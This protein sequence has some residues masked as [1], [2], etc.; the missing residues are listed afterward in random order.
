MRTTTHESQ[1]AWRLV[2]LLTGL[3]ALAAC[4]RMSPEQYAVREII[5]VEIQS[6]K[7]LTV[8]IP[9]LSGN[10]WN[11][12][13][14]RC[15]PEVWKAVTN[16]ARP[17]SGRLK[18]STKP[19]TEIG[20]VGLGFGFAHFLGSLSDVHY[21]FHITGKDGAKASVEITFPNAPSGSTH[22]EILVGKTPID[23]KP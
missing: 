15:A 5:P 8:E 22:A 18:S 17:F 23:T 14:L 12:V 11:D 20:G 2:P 6:D 19:D 9:S 10:G 1:A 4:G 3:C 21:L 7:P 13:G 16:G